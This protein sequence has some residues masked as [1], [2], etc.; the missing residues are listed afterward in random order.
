M[1]RG[2]PGPPVYCSLV[3]RLPKIVLSSVVRSTYQGESHGGV[4]LV[5]L[6]TREVEQVLDWNDRSIDWEGRGGDRGLRGIDFHEGRIL[7]AASDEIFVF[8][9]DFR[10]LGS[11][12]TP[13]LKHCHEIHVAGDRVFL[14]STGF[15]S[16]LEYDMRAE[17]WVGGHCL[18]HRPLWKIRRRLDLR[19]RPTLTAFD[20]RSSNG[21]SPG[22]TTHVNSVT[23][24]DGSLFVSGTGLGTLWAIRDG[25]L[26]RH[27]RIPYGSH[28]ARPFRGGTLMNHTR[29]DRIILAD[30][31]GRVRASYPLPTVDRERLEHADLP[32]DL[33]R[34]AFGRGL[35]VIDED[36]I[37]GGSSPATVSLYRLDPP[38][39]LT[40]V[41]LTMDVRN[42]VHGLEIWPFD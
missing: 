39:L 5:D 14:T 3:S 25:R 26:Q 2:A 40:S 15:D 35:A 42:A 34:P 7:L 8:D 16:I 6:E 30:R 1:R 29:S 24:R 4:Y 32:S 37:V 9:P 23:W 36:L 28:N 27:A 38:E 18:R 12:G 17:E 19:P 11:F 21:P 33:A 31:R 20:P 10:R 13:Y 41:N 22:D